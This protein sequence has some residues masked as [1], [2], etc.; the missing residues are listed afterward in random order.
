MTNIGFQIDDKFLDLVNN[1]KH[2][3]SIV[4]DDGLKKNRS[5]LM[6]IM[7]DEKITS[8]HKI[9]FTTFLSFE[10]FLFP[11]MIGNSCIK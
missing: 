5:V 11:W 2:L 8:K 10:L 4:T 7:K 9:Q 6:K 3:E 1:F